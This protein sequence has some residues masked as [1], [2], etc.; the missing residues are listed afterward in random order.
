MKRI[1][2]SYL[3]VIVTGTVLFACCTSLHTANGPGNGSETIAKIHGT[4]FLPGGVPADSARVILLRS[5]FN[6]LTDKEPSGDSVTFCDS[7]GHYELPVVLDSSTTYN[8]EIR[9]ISKQHIL[10]H[11]NI[12]GH[13]TSLSFLNDTLT[14]PGAV[15]ITLPTNLTPGKLFMPGSTVSTTVNQEDCNRG[16]AIFDSIPAGTA[17]PVIFAPASDQH[18]TQILQEP[19]TITSRSTTVC[20]NLTVYSDS[21][22]IIVDSTVWVNCCSF[23]QDSTSP[24]YEGKWSYRFDYS[25]VEY[26]AGAGMNLDNWGRQPMWDLSNCHSIRFAFR[27]LATGHSMNIMLRDAD[28]VKVN[29]TAGWGSS[30]TFTVVEVPLSYFEGINLHKIFEINF[31]V[32]GPYTGE[33]TVWIDDVEVIR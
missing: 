19:V 21:Q 2:L 30:D 28:S 5:N 31:G 24:A 15:T 1:L 33:G 29:V 20:R 17:A 13:D 23:R 9:S 4:V 12:S 7:Q 16:Y 10:T 18:S 22:S 26:Y 32:S 25:I 14:P 8:L 6:P 11:S 27:G 3:K